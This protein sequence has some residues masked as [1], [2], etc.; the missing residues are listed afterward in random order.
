MGTS[1][2][3]AEFEKKLRNLADYMTVNTRESLIQAGNVFKAE[4]RRSAQD[5]AGPDRKLSRHRSQAVLAAD[6]VI[7]R[8]KD[9]GYRAFANARGPWGIR[10]DSFA[11]GRTKAHEIKPKRAKRLVFYDRR[12]GRRVTRLRVYHQGSARDNYWEQ[13]ASRAKTRIVRSI[14][15]DILDTVRYGFDN[16][17]KIRKGA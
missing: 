7:K 3:P 10:D 12:I 8:Y 9:A 2:S 11:P 5:A 4:L 15:S 14:S 1:N 6:W 13:G 16:P 17:F